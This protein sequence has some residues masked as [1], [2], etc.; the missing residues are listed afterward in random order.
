M[1]PL[2]L[3]VNVAVKSPCKGVAIDEFGGSWYTDLGLSGARDAVQVEVIVSANEE[4]SKPVKQATVAVK[5]INRF[6]TVS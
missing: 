6:M 5:V 4:A 1:E 2:V 3:F